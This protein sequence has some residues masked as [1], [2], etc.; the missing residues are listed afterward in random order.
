M[1]FFPFDAYDERLYKEKSLAEEHRPDAASI[2]FRLN[3]VYNYLQFYSELKSIEDKDK[4]VAD[5][6]R[7]LQG[8]IEP[9][10]AQVKFNK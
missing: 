2:L 6:K 7:E 10:K 4:A 5:A 1:T 3:L 9:M 8:M